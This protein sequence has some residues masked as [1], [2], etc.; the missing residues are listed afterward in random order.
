MMAWARKYNAC[1]KNENIQDM[2]GN[3]TKEPFE[4]FKYC[5]EGSPYKALM[6]KFFEQ[7]AQGINA[8]EAYNAIHAEF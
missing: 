2:Y 8:T 4:H 6:E 7:R 3:P 5:P 1:Y